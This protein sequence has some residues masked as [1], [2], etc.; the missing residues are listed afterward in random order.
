[1]VGFWCGG[2]AGL[3]VVPGTRV[4]FAYSYSSE[5]FN[6]APATTKSRYYRESVPS[7]IPLALLFGLLPSIFLLYHTLLAIYN[8]YFH[9]LRALR[10]PRSWVAFP[11][12]CNISSCLGTYDRDMRS[13]HSCYGEVVRYHPSQASFITAA[14]W[15]DIYG[16]KHPQLP[17][18]LAR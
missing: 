2:F 12:L 17:K 4:Q 16:H 14:A 9:P 13:F 6:M 1:V 5:R 18:A 11:I 8:V 10:G 3:V 15:K 7:S